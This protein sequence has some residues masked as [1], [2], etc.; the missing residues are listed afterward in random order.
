MDVFEPNALPVTFEAAG[1]EIRS[2]EAGQMTVTF[3]EF[4]AGGDGRPLP[5]GL[6]GRQGRRD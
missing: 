6:P 5:R 4:P 2:T 3:R 1:A